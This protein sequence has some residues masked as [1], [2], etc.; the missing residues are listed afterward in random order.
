MVHHGALT[1]IKRVS[2]LS[3]SSEAISQFQCDR[4]VLKAEAIVPS[5]IL[6]LT[7]SE[8]DGVPVKLLA[9]QH[10]YFFFKGIL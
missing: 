5:C 2:L 9:A 3:L 7:S 1:V 6:Y 4:P 8:S 10:A